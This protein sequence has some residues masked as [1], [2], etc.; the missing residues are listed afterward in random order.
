MAVYHAE[1]NLKQ[2]DISYFNKLLELSP[3]EI[4]QQVRTEAR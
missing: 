3:D 2:E 4:L 1:L